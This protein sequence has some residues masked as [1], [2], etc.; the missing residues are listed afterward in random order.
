[1]FYTSRRPSH[2]EYIL[3]TL[4]RKPISWLLEWAQNISHGNIFKNLISYTFIYHIEKVV[5]SFSEKPIETLLIKTNGNILITINILISNSFY[6]CNSQSMNP[7][8]FRLLK[9]HRTNYET[10]TV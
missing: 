1:M 4:G 2:S 3:L 5:Y 10:L 6:S 9:L 8:I 7:M